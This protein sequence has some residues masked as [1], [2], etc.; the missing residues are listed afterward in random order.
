MILAELQIAGSWPITEQ[1]SIR[2]QILKTENTLKWVLDQFQE[3][4][5]MLGSM[6]E[7]DPS[8]A[9]FSGDYIPKR[10]IEGLMAGE[11]NAKELMGP[12]R[13]SA[14]GTGNT[15]MRWPRSN[16]DYYVHL[17]A[18]TLEETG[19]SF[20]AQMCLLLE[21]WSTATQEDKDAALQRMLANGV[22]PMKRPERAEV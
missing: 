15:S 2:S 8:I 1:Q 7:A 21:L 4:M 17:N 6:L 5:D 3:L 19:L 22:V 13:R 10:I 14:G 12:K 9:S 18:R 16:N 11:R 20:S